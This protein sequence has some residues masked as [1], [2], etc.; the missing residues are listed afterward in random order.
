MSALPLLRKRRFPAFGAKPSKS[1]RGRPATEVSNV[2]VY[3]KIE[4][5]YTHG[6]LAIQMLE[7]ADARP[8]QIKVNATAAL[9]AA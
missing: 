6:V 3:A 1:S 2:P 5:N 9:K 4:A 7:R 8:R